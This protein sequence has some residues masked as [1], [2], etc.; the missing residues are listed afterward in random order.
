MKRLFALLLCALLLV[1]CSPAAFASETVSGSDSYI[2][3]ETPLNEYCRA[4]VLKVLLDEMDTIEGDGYTLASHQQTLLVEI[5]SGF[6][7]GRTASVN[8]DIS[9]NWGDGSNEAEPAKPGDLV[10]VC[11]S[12]ASDGEL[13]G[14]VALFGRQNT[15]IWCG[16]IFLTLVLLFGGKK[17]LRSIIALVVTCV[18]M[19]GILMPL[20]LNGLN[21]ILGSCIAS[22]VAIALTLL[23][24][25]GFSTVSIAAALGA[26]GGL[27]VAGIL[28]AVLSAAFNMTGLIDEESMY[29]VQSVPGIDLR[30]ILFAAMLI[31]V[32]G[33]LI[34]VAVSIS[35]SLKELS[36]AS[37]GKLTGAELMASGVRIGVD[38]MGAS[39]NTLIFAYVGGSIH[40]L[41]LFHTYDIPF[42]MIINDEMIVAEVLRAM[43]GCFGLLMTV[44]IS[45]F[46]SGM[47][48]SKGNFG[49]FTLD[50][51]GSAVAIK[52][53]AE[54]VKSG[55]T[56]V[57]DRFEQLND[58][59]AFEKRTKKQAEEDFGEPENLYAKAAKRS[60]DEFGEKD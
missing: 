24:V 34:D 57:S 28:I 45:S 13:Y 21:P 35:S 30:G 55:W 6:Y 4:R 27:L 50:C 53:A 22:V 8:Y 41:L 25:Y 52:K 47:L 48:L 2:S 3:Q 32:L 46:V 29:L 42:K 5:K 31:G 15:L 33:G 38:I 23:I 59:K 54:R 14:F 51:F 9:D 37:E 56:R 43:V 44:P 11:V 10:I 7:K 19:I 39:L 49:K 16:V 36:E 26:Y 58:P 20:L 40:L 18:C 17:G 1:F 12:P 60:A